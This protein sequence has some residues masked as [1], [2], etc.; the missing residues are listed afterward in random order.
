[1]QTY[2]L[3]KAFSLQCDFNSTSSSIL[4]D[5][6]DEA[7]TSGA[8]NHVDRDVKNLQ[9]EADDS[10]NEEVV[11]GQTVIAPFKG[12]KYFRARVLSLQPRRF[13]KIY[14]DDGSISRLVLSHF[15]AISG[16]Q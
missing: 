5:A 8:L 1:M 15:E 2:I 10:E 6:A 16:I 9:K 11:V 3:T 13:F 4:D 12:N 7:M 14:F